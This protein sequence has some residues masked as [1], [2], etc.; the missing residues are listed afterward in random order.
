MTITTRFIKIS[1][2]TLAI[3]VYIA[4][5][6][7]TKAQICHFPFERYTK[8]IKPINWPLSY[9][10][11]GS[12][13]GIITDTRGKPIRADVYIGGSGLEKELYAYPDQEG[14]FL[15][16]YLPKEHKYYLAADAGAYCSNTISN[17]EVGDVDNPTFYCIQLSD[18]PNPFEFSNND[19]RITD[20][21]V[22]FQQ[23]SN[24]AI[25]RT[26]TASAVHVY[27]CSSSTAVPAS[28][29]GRR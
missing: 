17:I 21:A 19:H 28:A 1:A 20:M 11:R 12:V 16:K 5:L 26:R 14:K 9:A 4:I 18:S 15:F 2:T 25:Q 23:A 29:D 6:S 22:V 13:K 27:H 7:C 10:N 3:L 24:Q 8:A